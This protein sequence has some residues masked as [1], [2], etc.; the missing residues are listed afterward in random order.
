MG[1][2]LV[3]HPVPVSHHSHPLNCSICDE[4]TKASTLATSHL[5]VTPLS[6]LAIFLGKEPPQALKINTIFSP[7]TPI[8][9]RERDFALH[10]RILETMSE[11]RGLL[12]PSKFYFEG[13]NFV[14]LMNEIFLHINYRFNWFVVKDVLFQCA[15]Q[16]NKNLR[17]HIMI[18]S[19]EEIDCNDFDA[20]ELFFSHLIQLFFQEKHYLFNHINQAICSTDDDGSNDNVISLG[21]Y[22][23]IL[24]S[25]LLN[26]STLPSY[27]LNTY[28]LVCLD[29][30]EWEFYELGR[31]FVWF[32]FVLCS[33]EEPTLP[34]SEYASKR[35]VVFEIDN[36]F[37][38][39]WYPRYIGDAAE[40]EGG[41]KE[42]LYPFGAKFKVKGRKA[43]KISLKLLNY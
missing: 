8:D 23:L 26:W 15:S 24:N 3:R 20:K 19:N 17:E 36:S 13:V 10:P 6:Q 5:Y 14:T 43:Q 35:F 4:Y 11:Y 31:T 33:P 38:W 16:C 37:T 29:K 2:S 28:V 34:E 30:L 9:P 39:K 7:P 12:Y 21:L 41:R 27:R 18:G 22:A 1:S 32:S 25:L 42:Y 40:C